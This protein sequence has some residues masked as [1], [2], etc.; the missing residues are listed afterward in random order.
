MGPA[1]DVLAANDLDRVVVDFSSPIGKI[2]PLAPKESGALG[3]AQEERS[4]TKPNL[5]KSQASRS[6]GMANAADSKSAVPKT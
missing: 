5:A 6:G 3:D 1:F 4:A 2:L